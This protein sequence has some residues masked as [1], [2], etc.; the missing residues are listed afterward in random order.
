MNL[1]EHFLTCSDC[2]G[3]R[4]CPATPPT[5]HQNQLTCFANAGGGESRSTALRYSPLSSLTQESV[6]P[7][8]LEQT[9]RRRSTASLCRRSRC[10]KD[11]QSE[12]SCRWK[13]ELLQM[14]RFGKQ[15]LARI[16][17]W[18]LSSTGTSTGEKRSILQ[19]FQGKRWLCL[20]WGCWLQTHPRTSW[21]LS[22][23]T[24]FTNELRNLTI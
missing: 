20:H 7:L 14:G 17:G 16:G 24:G 6:V 15:L 19:Y 23:L 12:V 21:W 13:L 11:H 8:T 10:G 3:S 5:P 9:W 22:S 2:F 18:R 1:L 4:P